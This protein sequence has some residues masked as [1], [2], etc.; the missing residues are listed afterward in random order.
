MLSPGSDAEP[1][2]QPGLDAGGLLP[3]PAGQRQGDAAA[4]RLDRQGAEVFLG[5]A[6]RALVFGL[7][8]GVEQSPIAQV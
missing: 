4:G 3:V 1:A 5:G 6:Q 8:G 7:D 2:G